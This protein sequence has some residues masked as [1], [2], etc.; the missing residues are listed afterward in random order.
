[1][2]AFTA[3]QFIEWIETTLRQH[4]C[5]ERLIP[6]DDVLEDAFRRALGLARIDQ[7]I[8]EVAEDAIADARVADIPKTLRQ[9]VR[10]AMN[11]HVAWDQALYA[12]AKSKLFQDNN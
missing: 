12:L 3:P 6:A 10:E 1:M 11:D 2:N 4:G 8:T 9:Q 5:G 7:T